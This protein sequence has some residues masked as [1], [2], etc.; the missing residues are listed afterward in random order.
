MSTQQT[1]LQSL[2]AQGIEIYD[3]STLSALITCPRMCKY[4]HKLGLVP[5]ATEP[6][7][8]LEFGLAV[9]A[10]LET[11][12]AHGKDDNKAIQQFVEMFTP[13]EEQP[14][15]GKSGK[16]LAATYTVL[17][18]CS[19]LGEYFNKYRNDTREIIQLES[20][21]AEEV[22]P[23]VF[24][25]GR[26]DKIVKGPLGLVF[27]DY[28]TTKYMNDFIINPNPQFM[29]YKF[30]CEKLTGEKVSGELDIIGVS[31]SKSLAELLRR[32]PFDYSPYQMDQWRA[33]VVA[34][35]NLMHQ[36]EQADFW[37]QTWRCQP[38]FKNCHYLPLCTLPRPEAHDRLVESMYEV[39][40]WDPFLETT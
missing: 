12:Q 38:F 20:P 33:S 1:T 40:H 6:R 8:A 18:G 39:N 23:H 32:E 13:N 27:A 5:K 34:L 10:A 3:N 30:L 21:L 36:Y 16:E 4:R 29:T 14:T 2:Q 15:L 31:K 35:I 7:P 17:Y 22:G 19:I 28:K 26:V 37:P 25:A 24:L 9:H 11:W